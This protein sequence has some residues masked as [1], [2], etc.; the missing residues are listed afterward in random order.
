MEGIEWLRIQGETHEWLVIEHGDGRVE[1]MGFVV[2]RRYMPC[3]RMD[4]APAGD[5]FVGTRWAFRAEDGRAGAV[6]LRGDE[7]EEGGQPRI[8]MVVD[9]PDGSR[10]LWHIRRS[11]HAMAL[12]HGLMVEVP[13]IDVRCE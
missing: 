9:F 8:P 6:V 4:S 7:L 13:A 10:Q 12:R 3:Y 2:F 11:A 1:D 5:L